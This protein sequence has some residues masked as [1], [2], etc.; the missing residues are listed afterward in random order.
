MGAVV[1]DGPRISFVVVA[2]ENT[3]ALRTCLSSLLD[4]SL[5]PEQ[6]EI[7]VC[8]NTDSFDKADA[9]YELVRQLDS[10]IRYEWTAD[11]TAVTPFGCRH[12]RCLY[13]ATEIGVALAKGTWI[14]MPNADSYYAPPFAEAATRLADEADL[15]LVLCNFIHGHVLVPYIPCE[16]HPQVGRC[17][18]TA[19]LIRRE[20]FPFPWPGK[21]TQYEVADGVLVEELVQAGIR[22]GR[23]NATMVVHN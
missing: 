11:R 7:I 9:N 16:A 17:D 6:V 21:S 5:P 3:A 18:K 8:D 1:S 10:D 13:T 20:V 14:V 23:F 15:Q 4:Q 2:Y 22:W 19:M 12:A